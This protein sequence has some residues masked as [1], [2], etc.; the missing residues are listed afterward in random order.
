M[1]IVYKDLMCPNCKAMCDCSV[2]EIEESGQ[3]CDEYTRCCPKCGNTLKKKAYKGS[4]VL[5]VRPTR[6]PF[7]GKMSNDHKKTPKKPP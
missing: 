3:F 6:C 4:L 7:C 5:G 2:C 1:A